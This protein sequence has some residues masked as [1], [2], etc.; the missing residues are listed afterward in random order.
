MK[1]YVTIM[2][3]NSDEEPNEIVYAGHSFEDAHESARKYYWNPNIW[4]HIET[5]ENGQRIELERV[6]GEKQRK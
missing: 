1:I 5:W 3:L 2:L 6:S 4:G